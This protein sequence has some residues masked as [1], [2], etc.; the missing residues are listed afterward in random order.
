MKNWESCQSG[1]NHTLSLCFDDSRTPRSWRPSAQ[2][3]MEKTLTLPSPGRPGE[4]SRGMLL[5]NVG[6]LSLPRRTRRAR[7]LEKAK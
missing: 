3:A 2:R 5:T 7:R 6:N 1:K 4:G